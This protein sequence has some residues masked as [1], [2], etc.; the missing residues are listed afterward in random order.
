[1]HEEAAYVWRKH[2]LWEKAP[3]LSAA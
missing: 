2:K 3:T 1:V